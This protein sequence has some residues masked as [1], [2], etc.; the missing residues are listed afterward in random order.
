MKISIIIP[1]YNC[2]KTI[3]SCLQSVF[4]QTF[5]DFEVI[6][7]NDGS[8]DDLKIAMRLWMDKVKYIEQEN[9]GAPSARNRGFTESSGE[10]VIFLDADII[11]KPSM[12]AK[13]YKKLEESPKFSYA[14]SSFLWGWKKFKLWNFDEE[15]LKQIPYIHTSALIRREHFPGFDPN[16]KK[17]QDWDLWLTMLKKGHKGIWVDEILFKVTAE[18]TMSSWLPKFAYRLPFLKSKHKDKY[19]KAMAIIKDKHNL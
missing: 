14:Y 9:K 5:S 3:N 11:A 19:E 8:K 7:V 6:V 10:F 1:A 2:S 15:K 13:L 16:L 12:L 4:N 18:G 17:F